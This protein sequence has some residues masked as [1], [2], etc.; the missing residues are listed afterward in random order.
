M[1]KCYVILSRSS[2]NSTSASTKDSP[3]K[4]R[5]FFSGF[6]IIFFITFFNGF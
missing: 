3:V 1:K 6:L 5:L 4:T 2:R